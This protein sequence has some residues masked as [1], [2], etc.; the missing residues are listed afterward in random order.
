MYT[1]W[2]NYF[3]QYIPTEEYI[4]DNIISKGFSSL[5]FFIILGMIASM[6][7]IIKI[8]GKDTS[9]ATG[10]S[11]SIKLQKIKQDVKNLE[12]NNTYLESEI[13]IL[14]HQLT[15]ILQEKQNKEVLKLSKLTGTNKEIGSGI[16]LELSDSDNPLQSGE[17]P[18]YRIIHNTDLLAVINNLWAGG[19]KAISIN[20]QRVTMYTDIKC[21]GPTILINKTRVTSPFLIKA[22]GNPKKLVDSAKNGYLKSLELYGIK[23]R[24]EIYEQIEIPADGTIILAGNFSYIPDRIIN[25]SINNMKK[26][27][28]IA[29]LDELNLFHGGV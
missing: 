2:K 20:G 27:P 6:G 9:S 26:I 22:V 3:K 10:D 16:L 17:N 18:N 29:F 5:V 12:I 25:K 23:Y 1:D 24:M 13:L 19:A 7:L 28:N 14:N 4:P 8:E 11:I 15:Q 21:I